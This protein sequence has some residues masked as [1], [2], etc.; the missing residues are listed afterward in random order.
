MIKSKEMDYVFGAGI[1]DWNA[2]KAYSVTFIVTEDC[3]LRCKYCYQVHKNNKKQM[4]FEVAKKAVDHLLNNPDIFDAES[5]IWEFIGGE[6]L[7]E[8]DLIDKICDYIK[9]QTYIRKHKWDSKYRFSIGTNGTLYG[10][11]EMRKYIRKNKEKCSV[12]IT[13]DGTEIKHDLQRVYVDGS[14]SYGDVVKNIPLWLNEFP[15]STTKVTFGHEDLPYLKE[16]IIHLWDLGITNVPANIVFEDVWKEG[17][18]IIFENQLRELADYVIENRLWDKVNCT[19]FDENIGQPYNSHT[20]HSNFCGSGRM[21]AIDAEGNFYPCIRYVDFSL[22]NKEPIIIGNIDEG[23]DFDKVRPFLG[24]T[25]LT[26]SDEECIECEIAQGC[27]W[28]QGNN[29]DCSETGTIYHRAKYICEMHKAR[30]RANNYYWGK[31]F[32]E[33]GIKRNSAGLRKRHL[34]FI[35]SDDSIEHCN[36]NSKSESDKVMSDDVIKKGFE[37]AEKSFY[38]PVILNSKNQKNIKDLDSFSTNER[39]EVYNSS[40]MLPYRHYDGYLVLSKNDLDNIQNEKNCIL[41]LDETDIYNMAYYIEKLLEKVN[42]V[43][44]NL[45]IST[46]DFDLSMY[47]DQLMKITNIILDYYKSNIVKEV[48]VI[49]DRLFLDE[50]ENCEFGNYNFALAPNGKVYICP[51]F[52]YNDPDSYVG[53]LDNGIELEKLKLCKLEASTICKRCD[54]YQC[55]RCL[56]MNKKYTNEYN[57]PSSIQCQKSHIER[58]MSVILK[59]KMKQYNIVIGQEENIEE[60]NYDEPIELLIRD[61]DVNPYGNKI[62]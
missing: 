26:Q 45:K 56:Y 61:I 42:R 37:F 28:C 36:Y 5:V 20:L 51:S 57:T 2:G 1:K 24:L 43:N 54:A 32:K 59:E 41:N 48:N 12:G 15:N 44:I 22:S 39:I 7:L 58:K 55:D 4:S 34:Y 8:L 49:T 25:A 17:D 21:L 18:E 11:N 35:M 23:I 62:C 13:I 31:M 19:L 40:V 50:M 52:Y 33:F 14:G 60:L 29:Y 38:K 16:S 53:D 9:I 30:C 6:P 47:Q 3:N 10:S 46:R 27:A